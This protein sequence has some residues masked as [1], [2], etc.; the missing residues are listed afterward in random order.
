MCA[1]DYVVKGV[2]C[3]IFSESLVF[4][5]ESLLFLRKFVDGIVPVVFFFDLL[6][7]VER[8]GIRV[9]GLGIRVQG[10]GCRVYGAGVGVWGV[11]VHC[12][13]H[14]RHEIAWCRWRTCCLVRMVYCLLMVVYC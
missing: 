4:S 14:R 2:C 6:L 7:R 11:R 12:H 13:R 10:S 1:V 3:S 8:L 5:I 9:E